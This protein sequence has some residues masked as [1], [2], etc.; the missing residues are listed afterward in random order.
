M[1]K[2]RK[3]PR[4]PLK[5]LGVYHYVK[6]RG[7][8]VPLRNVARLK[9]AIQRL[10]DQHIHEVGIEFGEGS[11]KMSRWYRRALGG[12]VHDPIGRYLVALNVLVRR[13]GLKPVAIEDPIARKMGHILPGTRG[14]FGERK[15]YEETEEWLHTQIGKIAKEKNENPKKIINE[16]K[17]GIWYL[18]SRLMATNAKRLGLKA[19]IV[20]ESHAHDFGQ[21]YEV[22]YV[23]NFTR[24]KS[25]QKFYDKHKKLLLELYKR[26]KKG[27]E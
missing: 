27:R 25:N 17:M 8:R 22:I 4:P 9:Q 26:V 16:L 2:P 12:P 3:G 7:P 5:V 19:M 14:T 1:P 10:K 6:S 15:R 11:N 18:R 21:G 13:T 20:G 23:D 24:K